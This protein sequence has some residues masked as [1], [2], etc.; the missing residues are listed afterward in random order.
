M[1]GEFM[2][3]MGNLK[4]FHVSRKHILPL[5]CKTFDMQWKMEKDSPKYTSQMEAFEKF[6]TATTKL[7]ALYLDKEGENAFAVMNVMTD[8][9]SH[10]ETYKCIPNFQ[11]RPNQYFYRISDWVR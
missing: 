10:Q 9:V 5:I 4:R 6:K 7:S 3:Y 11:I 8:L 1:E 2:A